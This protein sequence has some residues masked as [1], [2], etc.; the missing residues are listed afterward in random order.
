MKATPLLVLPLLAL[1]LT[2]QDRERAPRPNRESVGPM[3]PTF[4]DAPRESRPMPSRGDLSDG[5]RAAP[6]R[7]SPATRT[8]IMDQATL[9]AP[10]PRSSGPLSTYPG[11]QIVVPPA[12]NR[13]QAFPDENYWRVRDLFNEFR[14]IAR[15]GL[16][17][18]TP[19]PDGAEELTDVALFPAGWRCYGVAI[20]AGGKLSVELSHS[21]LGWFRLMAVR[22]DGTPGPGMLNAMAA[23]RPVAFTLANPTEQAG[24]VYIIVD[25]P[26]WMSSKE[27]PYKLTFKRD[28]DPA[29]VDLTSVKMVQGM[30]GASPSVSAEF[31]GPSL[32]GPA[33]F[34]H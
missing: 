5:M 20:P 22:K 31:R 13:C 27:N 11:T 9:P 16:V 23:Y 29:K 26:G 33:V 12:W 32:S 6:S 34:P 28:W 21:N 3:R 30:W 7:T 14:W 25:D 2:A 24:A 17:P 4:N 8:K 18:V 15:S 1:G 10:V 19:V